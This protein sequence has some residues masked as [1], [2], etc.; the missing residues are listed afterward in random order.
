MK[1]FVD[2]DKEQEQFYLNFYFDDLKKVL[3]IPINISD[4]FIKEIKLDNFNLSKY[5]YLTYIE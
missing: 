5:T 4:E 3:K 1:S 2:F